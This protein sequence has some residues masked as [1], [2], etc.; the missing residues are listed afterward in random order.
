DPGACCRGRA[1]GWSEAGARR[2]CLEG[3]RSI[4]DVGLAAGRT[5][6]EKKRSYKDLLREEEEI[7]AQVR[8][9]SKKRLKDS[10]L[11]FLGTESHKKKRKH[12][13]DEFFYGGED[14]KHSGLM[15]WGRKADL[16]R[17]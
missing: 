16:G 8:K 7:A 12:S 5:Q 17:Y 2:E 10:D 15:L 6:R 1:A 3:D 14:R 9:T 13:S 11:F 4:D